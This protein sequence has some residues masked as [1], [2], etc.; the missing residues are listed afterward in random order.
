TCRSDA[1]AGSPRPSTARPRPK[2]GWEQSDRSTSLLHRLREVLPGARRPSP[3]APCWAG[4]GTAAAQGVCFV[5]AP[6]GGRRG[7]TG[8]KAHRKPT[9]PCSV[10]RSSTS[11]RY[12]PP[13]RLPRRVAAIA[14]LVF[15]SLG[16]AHAVTVGEVRI[17]GLDEEMENNVRGSLSLVDAA[18]QEV[19]GRRMGYLVRTAESE[20]REALEPFGFYSPVIEVERD[21]ADTSASVT[22]RVDPGQPVRVRNSDIAIIGEGGQDRYLQSDLADFI[23]TPGVIF[24]H[25]DYEASKIRISRRLT[26]RGYFDADFSSRRV[27]VTRAENAAD[28]DLVWTSGIRYDM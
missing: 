12:P 20:A 26:E 6:A 7:S 14:V 15:L 22:I 17:L 2:A 27:E 18:G 13:M 21:R 3:D 11:L 1:A 23:P 9:L 10:N 5:S 25:A 8:R 16:T 28:I 19:S 24:N 4:G